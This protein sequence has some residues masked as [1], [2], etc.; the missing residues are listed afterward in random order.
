[1]LAESVPH[2]PG[3]QLESAQAT[4]PFFGSL[5]T[6]AV[7]TCVWLDW[8]VEAGGVSAMEIAPCGVGGVT[9]GGGDPLGEG[10]WALEIDGTEA[11]PPTRRATSKQD[12]AT[13]TGAR[14]TAP[15]PG[16]EFKVQGLQWVS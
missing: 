14:A 11:Q 13:A 4:P 5:E 3:A 9:A 15:T 6:V 2:A 8:I 10:D 12:T 7:K 16:S 1:V